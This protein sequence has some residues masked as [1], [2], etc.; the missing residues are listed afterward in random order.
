[1][2][3]SDLLC[4]FSFTFV[5][6]Y[7]EVHKKCPE[8]YK[9]VWGFWTFFLDHP[10]VV[11]DV[12]PCGWQLVRFYRLSSMPKRESLLPQ[13]KGNSAPAITTPCAHFLDASLHLYMRVCPSVRR[14][15]GPSVRPSVGRSRFR[16]KRENR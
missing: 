5:V 7:R 14:S 16:Q 11:A 4:K 2:R 10:I 9:I 13:S 15:V 1:M 8:S 12:I 6:L 3:T